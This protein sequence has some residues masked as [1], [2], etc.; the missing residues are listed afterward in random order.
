MKRIAIVSI[1]LLLAGAAAAGTIH[2]IRTGVIAEGTVVEVDGA[3]VTAVQAKSFTITELPA[4][5]YTAIWVYQGAAPSV[6][7][8]DVVHVRGL[9][10]VTDQR[11]EISLLYPADAGVTV[12]GNAPVPDLQMTTTELL[13]DPAAWESHVLTL[14]DGFIVQE[15]M[16]ADGQWRVQSVETGLDLVFDDY[17]FDF[18]SVA[19]G[20]CYNNAYG[21]FTWFT[22]KYVFKVMETADTDCTVANDAVTFSHLKQLY[23]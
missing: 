19:L 21:M 12:T 17:F 15:L 22:G 6:N 13:A 10:R 11:G 23:R 1:A 3:V 8:G 4:G 16:P 5:P 9:A 20:D 14:T 7:V 2:D 18:A